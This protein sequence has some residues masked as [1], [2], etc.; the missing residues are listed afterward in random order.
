MNFNN[1]FFF[2][3]IAGVPLL[4]VV[5]TAGITREEYLIEGADLYVPYYTVFFNN[6]FKVNL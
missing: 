4:A 6:L 3:L 1:L 2:F 5:T